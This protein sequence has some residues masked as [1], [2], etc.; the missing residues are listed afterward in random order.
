MNCPKCDKSDRVKVIRTQSGMDIFG[1][2]ITWKT[3]LCKRCLYY[4][5]SMR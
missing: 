3:R 5:D 4:W 1:N 2:K